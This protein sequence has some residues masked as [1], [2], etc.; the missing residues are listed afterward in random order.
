MNIWPFNSIINLP[1]VKQSIGKLIKEI[2]DPKSGYGY[3]RFNLTDELTV[4]VYESLIVF[5]KEKG[6]I[7]KAGFD[8][9]ICD[10]AKFSDINDAKIQ[11]F[12]KVDC[13]K[14]VLTH[15]LE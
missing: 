8:Q 1:F 11:W 6:E 12:L 10:G 14:T 3:R 5:L 2:K 13:Y 4:L 7:S 9:R 15:W